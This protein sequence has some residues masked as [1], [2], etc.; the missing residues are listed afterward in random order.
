MHKGGF[1]MEKKYLT[2]QEIAQEMDISDSTAYKIIRQLN[3]ELEAKGFITVS[4]RI[5]AKYFEE[6]CYC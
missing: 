5:P 6:R 1:S 3:A 4:G 2:A